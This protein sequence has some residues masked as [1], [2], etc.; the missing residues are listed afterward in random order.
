[1]LN[2]IKSTKLKDI[3]SSACPENLKS[4]IVGLLDQ[5]PEKRFGPEA[6]KKHIFFEG[7][8]WEALLTKTFK[9]PI[10]PDPNA[11]NFKPD[12]NVE[13]VFGLSKPKENLTAPL[14]GAQQQSFDGWDWTAADQELPTPD[15]IKVAKY[16]KKKRKIIRKENP[17]KDRNPK[18]EIRQTGVQTWTLRKTLRKNEIVIKFKSPTISVL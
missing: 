1:M 12:A 8:D 9:P 6:I 2:S 15:P 11:V 4:L 13:E 3:F 5:D 17:L 18:K 16:N 14:S 10:V 7:Y